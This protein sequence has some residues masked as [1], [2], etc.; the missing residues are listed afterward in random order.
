MLFKENYDSFITYHLQQSGFNVSECLKLQEILQSNTFSEK[1]TEAVRLPYMLK[2]HCKSKLHLVEPV[3]QI[4][5]SETGQKIGTYSYVPIRDA[6]SNYCSHE[7][8]DED[9]EVPEHLSS[10]PDCFSDYTDGT[11]FKNHPFFRDNPD[12]LRLHFYEDEFEVVN[13]LGSK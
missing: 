9:I 12:A 5:R 8:I 2:E 13:P 4:L 11:H 6:L 7:D 1:A 3:H 10:N